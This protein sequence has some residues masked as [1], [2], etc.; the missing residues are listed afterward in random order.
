MD[1]G[2]ETYTVESMR[3]NRIDSKSKKKAPPREG[4]SFDFSTRTN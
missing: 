1:R 3:A 2:T 4:W